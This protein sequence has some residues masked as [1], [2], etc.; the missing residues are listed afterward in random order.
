MRIPRSTSARYA[1]SPQLTS[2][3]RTP[4]TA[5]VVQLK[6]REKR[7]RR[8]GSLR[9]RLPAGDEIEALVELGEHLRDLGRIVLEVGID[10]HDE[11]S[12]RLEES[13]LERGGLAEV[14]AQVDD[15]D[16][17]HLVVESREDTPCSRPS[18]RRRRRR[19]RSPRLAARAAAAISR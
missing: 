5:P 14:P 6:T 12:A 17:G 11:V 2:W 19:P 4:E 15:D 13:R 9:L 10:R 7:R 1:F 18:S 8:N 3:S 16:V